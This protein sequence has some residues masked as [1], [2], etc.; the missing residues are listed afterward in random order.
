MGQL[1]VELR[2]QLSIDTPE[3]VSLEYPLAGIG[4]RAIACLIDY[5][6]QSLAGFAVIMFFVLIATMV[7]SSPRPAGASV[8]SSSSDAWVTAI[9]FLILFGVQWGY[10]TLFETFWNGRTP[11]KRILRLR[12]MQHN[13]RS[14]GFLDALT[15]NLLRIVD[16]IPGF[17]LVGLIAVF[18]T[19][20]SQRLGD[21]VAGTIV[22]HE[23]KIETPLWDG[24]GARHLT[25]GLA[26]VFPA[27]MARSSGI[28]ADKVGRLTESDLALLENFNSRKLDLP[29]D[30]SA[31][32]A[33]RLAQ[34]MAAKMQ[35]AVP[36]DVSPD[37]FLDSLA[38]DLRSLGRLAKS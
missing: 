17:Y 5:T 22:V 33:A 24:N 27:Q 28:P 16:I 7:P 32:L 30:T 38:S 8:K 20:Q 25:A 31:A 11:G 36:S 34:Q 18:A 29:L 26:R 2:D 19:R 35:T 12:V 37:T 23:Q 14:I 3:L 6:I 1:P 15:R 13:G 9:I 10:F 4:S 21:L